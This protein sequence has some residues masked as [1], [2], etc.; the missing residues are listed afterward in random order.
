MTD[1]NGIYKNGV[2]ITFRATIL[3]GL[4]G[5]IIAGSWYAGGFSQDV[6]SMKTDITD[7]TEGRAKIGAEVIDLQTRAAAADAT[8]RATEQRL[9]SI[10]NTLRRIERKID[11][12]TN[13]SR[14]EPGDNP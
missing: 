6:A 2:R 14:P 11:R 8:G 13:R 9:N 10:D 7:N 3:I 1:M 4:L 12:A 5:T